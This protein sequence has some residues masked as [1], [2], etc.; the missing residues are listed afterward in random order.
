MQTTDHIVRRFRQHL[1][2]TLTSRKAMAYMT[3]WLMV[4]GVGVLTL[5]VATDLGRDWLALGAAGLLPALLIAAVVAHRRTP[6][7]ARVRALIDQRSA[8]GGLLMAEREVELG[9]WAERI[10][11]LAFPHVTWRSGRP[12]AL[13][14]AAAVFVVGSFLMPTDLGAAAGSRPL[15]VGPEVDQLTDQIETLEQEEVLD[16]EEAEVLVEKLDQLEQEALADDPTRTWEALDHLA[17]E[18]HQVADASAEQML[19]QAQQMSMAEALADSLSQDG[20]A[21]DESMLADAMAELSGLVQDATA[22]NMQLQMALDAMDAGLMQQLQLN[23]L[24]P[25]Q[26]QKLF[27][28]MQ[29]GGPDAQQIARQFKQLAEALQQC[30]NGLGQCMG[31]LIDAQLIDPDA[32]A[33]CEGLGQCNGNGLAEFLAACEGNMALDAALE[34]WIQ[35]RPGQGGITRGRGDAP[36]TWTHGADEGGTAFNEQILPPAALAQLKD[37]RLIGASIGD[38]T[39]E[40]PA[41]PSAHGAL[42]GASAGGGAAVS[43]R[44]LPRHRESVERFFNRPAP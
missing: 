7:L 4:W 16:A 10:P 22:S 18:L 41:D 2:V 1:V 29:Q 35:G 21:Y 27:D 34:L 37:S 28:A 40:Q 11:A 26:M 3:L 42:S 43:Q 15:D 9:A 13:F 12:W 33:Q 17:E 6:G 38:P 39:A 5:R 36:M 8:A 30:Q 24:T 32:L 14:G 19:E 31:R 23:Q 20:A 44:I 25:E